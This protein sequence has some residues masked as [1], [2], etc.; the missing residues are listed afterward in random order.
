MA[1]KDEGSALTT[2][3]VLCVIWAVIVIGIIEPAV[4]S[5]LITGLIMF[6]GFGGI[7]QIAKRVL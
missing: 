3:I 6:I 1:K 4:H 5:E 7:Y 2:I